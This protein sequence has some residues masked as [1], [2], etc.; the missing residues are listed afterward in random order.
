MDG[1]LK[2]H[3]TNLFHKYLVQRGLAQV[4]AY[5]RH[6]RA[7]EQA[8]QEVGLLLAADLKAV[9]VLLTG[10]KARARL[11]NL[12]VRLP[13]R[14]QI[15]VDAAVALFYLAQVALQNGF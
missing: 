1:S 7:R 4:K 10:E 3:F 15:E 5:H 14:F 8:E 13:F 12:L 2:I 9:L 6:A 11:A